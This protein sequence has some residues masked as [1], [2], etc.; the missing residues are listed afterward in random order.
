MNQQIM[1][2]IRNQNPLVLCLTNTVTESFCANVLLAFGASPI[3]SHAPEEL[4]ELMRHANAVVI[5]IGTLTRQFVSNAHLAIEVANSRNKPIILDPVGAGAS[6]LRTQTAQDFINH[7]HQLILKCNASELMAL[8]GAKSKIKGVDSQDHVSEFLIR[9]AQKLIQKT[10]IS[11]I[12]LTGRNDYVISEEKILENTFGCELMT[13]VSGMGCALNA[14]LAAASNMNE[15]LAQAMFEALQHYTLAGQKAG[16]KAKGAGS[17]VTLFL[18]EL[19][20]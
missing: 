4:D 19:S 3:M 12:I 17:F 15:L 14:C 1:P 16:E 13:R 20:K 11:H 10:S 9:K 6:H 8:V 5:N 7:A 18:D 2:L